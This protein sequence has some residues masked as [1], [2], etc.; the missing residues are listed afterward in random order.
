MNLE[1]AFFDKGAWPHAPQELVLGD[2]FAGR[3]HQ[4]FDDFKRA[5]ANGDR[6]P[7]H[8]QLAPA[9]VDLQRSRLVHQLR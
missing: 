4:G 6:G 9:G 5:A 3:L 7:S 8:S 1:R 2:K